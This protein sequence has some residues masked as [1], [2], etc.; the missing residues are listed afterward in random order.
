MALI[1]LTVLDWGMASLSWCAMSLRMS[2]SRLMRFTISRPVCALFKTVPAELLYLLH[3]VTLLLFFS[4]AV[5]LHSHHPACCF[6]NYPALHPSAFFLPPTSISLTSPT[7][8]GTLGPLLDFDLH[9]KPHTVVCFT[10][11]LAEVSRLLLYW[12]T[13][14]ILIW[15]KPYICRQQTQNG[16]HEMAARGQSDTL[17]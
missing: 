2:F 13:L 16:R 4:P 3:S 14:Y 10:L 15:M 9:F 11:R 1:L 12:H 6:C 8:A 17:I 7:P 5:P